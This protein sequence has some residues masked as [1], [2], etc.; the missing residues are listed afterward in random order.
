MDSGRGRGGLVQL[1]LRSLVVK[2][3]RV[4]ATSPRTQAQLL[5]FPTCK[6]LWLNAY[7]P[8]DPQ[9]QTFNDTELLA[10]LSEIENLVSKHNDC[11]VVL[12]ADMNWDRSRDNH[13]TRTV[14][15]AV[16]RI[17]LTSV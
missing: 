15:T 4:V 9:L 8:C 5:N 16:E 7:T 12:A 11:E 2:Q 3:T 10:T 1:S 13:F 14:A 17:G 6:V